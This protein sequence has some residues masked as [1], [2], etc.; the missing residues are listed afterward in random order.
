MGFQVFGVNTQ[1][2][3]CWIWQVYSQFLEEPPYHFPQWPYQFAVHQQCMRVPISPHPLQYLLLLVLL[4]I[5]I[6]IGVRQYLIVVLICIFL[7]ASDVEH[8]FIYLL[9]ICMSSREKCLFRSSDHFLIGSFVF[10]VVVTELY[11]FFVYFGYQALFGGI[12]CKYIFPFGWLSLYLV[13]SFF[14]CAKAFQFTVVPFICFCFYF[15]C[16]EAKCIKSIL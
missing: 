2:R 1:Q 5:A 15:P 6:L 12:A 10:V 3:Y 13:D 9:A 4:I 14:C 11:E 16:L 7:I 8:L